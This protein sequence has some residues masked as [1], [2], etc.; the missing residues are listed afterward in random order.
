M[1][2]PPTSD[3]DGRGRPRRGRRSA[4]LGFHVP[5][6]SHENPRAGRGTRAPPVAHAGR[7]PASL[8]TATRVGDRRHRDRVGR[9]VLAS[10]L[11][12]AR[13]RARRRR[14][15]PAVRRV[16][17]RPLARDARAHLLEPLRLCGAARDFEPRR[18][19][20]AVP[21]RS[22]ARRDRAAAPDA[23]MAT[24]RRA[25][26]RPP[27]RD[28]VRRAAGGCAVAG[29][30]GRDAVE[31]PRV[32]PDAQSSRTARVRPR[33]PVPVRL[34]D[35]RRVA[36]RPPFVRRTGPSRRDVG[37]A[38]AGRDARA[39]VPRRASADRGL[40]RGAHDRLRA[41]ARAALRSA[42]AA[43]HDRRRR[44][45]RRRALGRAVVACAPLQRAILPRGSRGRPAERGGELQS[46]GSGSR[47]TRLAVG[48]RLWR[49]D[50]LGRHARDRLSPVRRGDRPGLRDLG[51][52]AIPGPGRRGSA[53]SAGSRRD[54]GAD[55]ARDPSGRLL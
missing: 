4:I 7:R 48:R 51:V 6:R 5:S 52:V 53:V 41:R 42:H 19:A 33:R 55:V 50:L 34:L 15:L 45:S 21:A 1:R 27:R 47:R 32:G 12:G 2:P 9:A 43:R 26:A 8:S 40:H 20:S 46:G 39:P 18:L 31:R 11:R 24:A 23:R 44:P 17:P 36:C 13:L 29:G 49:S 14:R 35:A 28:A 37:D 25:A 10:T 30:A 3:R 16:L 22:P 54:R 38:R